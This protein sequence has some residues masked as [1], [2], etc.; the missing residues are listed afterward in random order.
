VGCGGIGGA[1]R[2]DAAG[3]MNA[4]GGKVGRR[5]RPWPGSEDGRPASASNA[6]GICV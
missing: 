1:I 4:G 3:A 2:V 5:D 6:R